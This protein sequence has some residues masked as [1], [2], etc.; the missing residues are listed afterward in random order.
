MSEL[1][2]AAERILDAHKRSEVDW[3]AMRDMELALEQ[4]AYIEPWAWVIND[5]GTIF[6]PFLRKPSQEAYDE[7]KNRGVEIVEL[8]RKPKLLNRLSRDE[9][10]EA[11]SHVAL[12]MTKENVEFEFANAIIDRM[13]EKNK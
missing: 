10:I 6:K 4:D 8:Y 2:K 11:S 3:E 7:A 12:R 5:N 1:R 9:I 13:M